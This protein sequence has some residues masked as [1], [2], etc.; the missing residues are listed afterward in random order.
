MTLGDA[1]DVLE[2]EVERTVLDADVVDTIK[3]EID[4]QAA[5]IARL[6]S[7]L[8]SYDRH[9]Q[10]FDDTA[11]EGGGAAEKSPRR[12]VIESADKKYRFYLV[13]PK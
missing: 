6:T 4:R 3:A 2:F 10:D 12:Q 5:R 1:L 8:E 11:S 7:L 9:W 13:D